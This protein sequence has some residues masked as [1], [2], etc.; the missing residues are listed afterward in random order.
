MTSRPSA[1]T[2]PP[3]LPSAAV[4][5]HTQRVA[6]D[7]QSRAPV[8][9]YSAHHVPLA[10]PAKAGSGISGAVSTGKRPELVIDLT[11]G[12][13]DNTRPRSA[14][15]AVGGIPKHVSASSA[16][17]TPANGS[18]NP[19]DGSSANA[20]SRLDKRGRPSM[21]FIDG[22]VGDI[23]DGSRSASA[24]PNT[25][26]PVPF[27]ARPGNP[28]NARA[29]QLQQ[30]I[31]NV[32]QSRSKK[33]KGIPG[34][35]TLDP[36]QDA[37]KYPNAS[38]NTPTSLTR[39][40]TL[41]ITNCYATSEPADFSPWTGTQPEDHLTDK[42]IK[43]GFQSTPLVSI[44]DSNTAR[45]SL[46]SSLK[47]KSGM[48]TLSSLFTTVLERRQQMGKLTA[49][50]TFKPPPR[51]ALTDKSRENWLLELANANVPLRRL[52]RRI[53]HGIRGKGLL[54]ECMGK[55][56]PFN[57]AVWLSKCIGA[58]EMR[59]FKR[60]GAGT[61]TTPGIGGEAK[62]V[63]EW[64]GQVQQ[65][66][67]SVIAA[68]GQDG[69]RT[70]IDYAIK[71]VC[72]LYNEHLLDQD[73]Y[74]E[75][76]LASLESSNTDRL[77]MWL[78]MLQIYWSDLVTTRRR[79]KRLAEALL[80]HLHHLETAESE[81]I[82]DKIL[83]RLEQALAEI[84]V[85]HEACLILPKS[86]EKYKDIVF[87]VSQWDPNPALP[88]A[89]NNLSK[90]NDFLLRTGANGGL[91]NSPTKLLLRAL[92]AALPDVLT[93]FDVE[94]LSSSCMTC[95]LSNQS[96]VDTT[97]RWA[98]SKYR[99]GNYRTYLAVRLLRRWKAMGL[100]TD[101]AVLDMLTNLNLESG[102]EEEAL[103]KIV[104]ELCRS[105][106]FSVGRYLQWLIAS[107][108]MTGDGDS[109]NTAAPH[110]RILAELPLHGLPD[111]LINLRATL[112]S[113]AGQDAE[114]VSK[115][116]EDLQSRIEQIA[117]CEVFD[118]AAIGALDL[119][120]QSLP[121]KYGLSRWLRYNVS[122]LFH[123]I[124]EPPKG[125]EE[126]PVETRVSTITPYQFYVTR[127]LLEQ[128]NDAAILADVVG[129]STSS[130]DVAVLAGCADVLNL[131][132]KSFAAIG[133]L[134]P[135]LDKLT[136][137]YSQLRATQPLERQF[138]FAMSDLASG[139]GA[140]T[141]LVQQL[142]LDLSTCEQRAAVAMCSPASDGMGDVT[143]TGR[144]EL[145][146]DEEIERIL[147]S[148][149]SMDE[150]QAGRVFARIV[151][152]M[153]EQ[154]GGVKV[155]D[156][157]NGKTICPCEV[158]L[159]KLRAFDEKVFERLLGDWITGLLLEQQP[160]TVS[161]VSFALPTII[162]AGV[163][164]LSK[165]VESTKKL[166]DTLGKLDPRRASGAALNLLTTLIP[167]A[168]EEHPL[169]QPQHQYRFNIEVQKQ[170]PTMIVMLKP[171]LHISAKSNNLAFSRI[172]E[173]LTRSEGLLGPLRIAAVKDVDKVA[174]CLRITAAAS[175]TTDDRSL[176]AILNSLFIPCRPTDS[177]DVDKQE[178]VRRIIDAAD[179]FS[180]PFCQLQ[181]R[182]LL[183]APSAQASEA[184][185][186][187][188]EA[189]LDAI[190]GAIER[191]S[192]SWADLLAGFGDSVCT[193][194]R[195]FAEERIMRAASQLPEKLA[196]Y[197]LHLDE[198][199]RLKERVFLRRY[200]SVVDATSR[201]S[202]SPA[203]TQYISLLSERFKALA[204]LLDTQTDLPASSGPVRTRVFS[205]WVLAMVYL[206]ITHQR[207]LIAASSSE[208][209][210]F[211]SIL[212]SMLTNP[213]LQ[214]SSQTSAA[215]F[216]LLALLSDGTRPARTEA[217]QSILT[218]P[219]DL[220]ADVRAHL[221]RVEVQKSNGDPRIFFLFGSSSSPEAWLGLVTSISANPPPNVTSTPKNSN[222]A[223]SSPAPCSAAV[224]QPPRTTTP[225]QNAVQPPMM[226]RQN[227]Q[228]SSMQAPQLQRQNSQQRFQPQQLHPSV[229]PGNILPPKPGQMGRP[230]MTQYAQV[231]Q[232]QG[233]QY[234]GQ[235][236]MQQSRQMQ[237]GWP[238]MQQTRVQQQQPPPPPQQRSG[239]TS[240]SQAQN[241]SQNQGQAQA[242]AQGQQQQQGQQTQ[243]PS[244]TRL[245]YNPPMPF[246]L[247]R[248]EI[249]PDASAGGAGVGTGTAAV[250]AQTK[251]ESNDTAISLSL[252]G[253]R[254]V[255]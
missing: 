167:G 126:K 194:V 130:Y 77:P 100:D 58:N 121:T 128:L 51:V 157:K 7:V 212:C 91:K 153:A 171:L 245:Q 104:A 237:Q 243:L 139:V 84:V 222:V 1:Q 21:R 68:C 232:H 195:Q 132:S 95:G 2:R 49:P 185:G 112:L 253:A 89:I 151:G 86:W 57:R 9:S 102:I 98:C 124:M 78:I 3:A 92:D 210:N 8:R 240:Q 201:N 18:P 168:L 226:Q 155:S 175:A 47:N 99:S 234:Q 241:Q 115:T 179:D 40:S 184:Q 176:T 161:I 152:R 198:E 88:T 82:D 177:E 225:Q 29:L 122:T 62:W 186:S 33:A 205:D 172:V 31:Q 123:S 196:T 254:R 170:K 24:P 28:G 137:K 191:E 80:G 227:S 36:P 174:D 75:W 53:P 142:K 239:Q 61:A 19:L 16:P 5:G 183:S 135:L 120:K 69:W 26:P 116:I 190:K 131:H 35:V 160:G 72:H 140:D 235:A 164:D 181:I 27:P 79:G 244:H 83:Q 204:E 238:P 166:I 54:E 150:G 143:L 229:Y 228:Q 97:I 252:F 23:N 255:V 163:A 207:D 73:Q 65:Y 48:Q 148:G 214:Q 66:L 246:P 231:Q 159:Q 108:S 223:A 208:Q 56:V 251:A 189:L 113:N 218:V 158:W 199:G 63:K 106:H 136:D 133:A 165:I 146:A 30:A 187:L 17:G 219:I 45:P 60:K 154:L 43:S 141:R 25:G 76:L 203:S 52:S 15:G 101:S 197:S 221:S 114:I 39:R 41:P 70:K 46:W 38:K 193:K 55:K 67:E 96:I 13:G 117:K 81:D 217:P 250:G 200:L 156:L 71:L 85:K 105:K 149:T 202:S 4:P 10:G 213:L 249:L 118:I 247:R 211:V 34:I 44:H 169:V 236:Q 14:D 22:A 93:T 224:S 145:N 127:R 32:Q 20:K 180:L 6:G 87:K 125:A 147:A 178:V 162:G 37:R 248:W 94:A 188:D 103:F 138:V 182:H 134:S 144:G 173:E 59:A 230:G 64:T 192:S 209:L 233:H 242:Q 111:H 12:E 215:L 74:L 90:R 11:S 110:K 129:M 216:D 107:G 119:G 109:S 42:L 220:S 50:S 206:G